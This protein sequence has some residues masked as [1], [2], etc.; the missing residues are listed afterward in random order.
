MQTVRH[1]SFV[2]LLAA[3]GF[4]CGAASAEIVQCKNHYILSQ[5]CY[6]APFGLETFRIRQLY[7]SQDGD[8]QFIELEN[9][10]PAGGTARLAGARLSVTDRRGRTKTLRFDADLSAGPMGGRRAAIASEIL[11]DLLREDYPYSGAQEAD[12]RIPARFLP[13]DGGTIVLAGADSWTYERLPTDGRTSLMRSGEE[14]L[15]LATTFAGEEFTVGYYN[16]TVREFRHKRTGEYFL[17]GSEPELE[18]L[19]RPDSGWEL[20]GGYFNSRSVA[21]DGF[22]SRVFGAP[23]PVCRFRTT[24]EHGN[25]QLFVPGTEQCERIAEESP[26]FVLELAAAFHA[27]QPDEYS[28][29][30]PMARRPDSGVELKALYRLHRPE[31]NELRYTTRRSVRDLLEHEGWVVEAAMCVASGD[32]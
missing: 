18:E 24:E 13:T 27:W 16:L 20:T 3:L 1:F 23:Q 21:E 5:P 19:L 4:A 8:F 7:S 30:C 32:L 11:D 15:G 9:T 2:A 12:F 29:A 17:T 31:T 22:L 14:V 10:A 26:G 25:A 28:G 6:P